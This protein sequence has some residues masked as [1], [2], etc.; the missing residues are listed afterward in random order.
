MYDNHP[1]ST[2]E[3]IQEMLRRGEIQGERIERFNE[4]AERFMREHPVILAIIVLPIV[5]VIAI[6]L[7]SL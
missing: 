1:L 3:A 4:K 7:L 6:G 5:W 2:K